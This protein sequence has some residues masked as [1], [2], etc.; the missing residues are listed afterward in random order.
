[1]NGWP[2]EYLYAMATSVGILAIRRM[3]E[4][5]RWC[6]LVMSVESW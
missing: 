5:W 6:G 1:M 3:A 4:T 2:C